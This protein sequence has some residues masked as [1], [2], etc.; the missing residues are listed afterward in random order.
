MSTSIKILG[1][2]LPNIPWEDRPKGTEAPVWRYGRNPIIDRR[3][4]QRSNSIF[5]SAVVPFK[6]AFAGVFRI[7]DDARR[8]NIHRGASEDGITWKIDDDPIAFVNDSPD[9]PHSDYKYDPRVIRV[10]DRFYVMWCDGNH[11]ASIGAGYTT[12][13]ETFHRLENPFPPFNRNGVL[14]PRKIKGRFAVLHRP[15]DSGHTPFGDIFYSESPDLTYWGKH[16]WVMGTRGSDSGWQSTKIGAGAVPVETS[17]GWLLIYHGVLT[18]CNGFIYAW[19]AA[20]LDLEEPWKV[21]YRGRRYLLAPQ[22]P[23]ECIGDVPNVAFPCASLQDPATGRIAIYY[24]GADTCVNLAFGYI[25]EIV[26]FIKKDSI[27]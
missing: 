7:D 22:T 1:P 6:K 26:D 20:L 16:R 2:A 13:F 17:E 21:R 23:Y 12:D 3:A 5:N 9:L 8:M 14:F 18:S 25:G 11:G 19:G 15:S 4:T 27:S 10:E 24:G